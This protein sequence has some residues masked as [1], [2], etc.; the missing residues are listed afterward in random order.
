MKITYQ[1]NSRRLSVE[2]EG[3]KQ[4]DVFGSIA[5]FQEVFEEDIC[6]KCKSADV[7]FVVRTVDDNNYHE[8][9][10]NECRAKLAFGQHKTGGSLF[11]KRK[12]KDGGWLPDRGWVK[13]NPDTKKEE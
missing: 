5:Q 7:R 13:Y 4:T 3:D 1:S 9:Q 12:D 8:I 2:I 6:Q 11:P 10:C